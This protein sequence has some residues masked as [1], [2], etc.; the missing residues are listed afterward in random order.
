[1]GR[2]NRRWRR[3]AWVGYVRVGRKA[4]GVFIDRFDQRAP[5]DPPL[6][7]KLLIDL[8]DDR[9]SGELVSHVPLWTTHLGL[10]VQESSCLN[11]ERAYPSVTRR[12]IR[13]PSLLERL[14]IGFGCHAPYRIRVP[15]LA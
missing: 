7:S 3:S 4:G 5:I 11:V 2:V 15:L 12:I 8:A 13:K 6:S 10:T 9:R 14:C 1:M